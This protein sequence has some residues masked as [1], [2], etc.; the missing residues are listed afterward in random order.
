MAQH[1]YY[2]LGYVLNSPVVALHLLWDT[3]LWASDLA[4]VVDDGVCVCSTE[5][6]RFGGTAHQ[7]R[8]RSESEGVAACSSPMH[9]C[10]ARIPDL[11]AMPNMAE[12]KRVTKKSGIF[13]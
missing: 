9:R 3:I 2:I 4:T 10:T 8:G 12:L 11:F 13:F 7:G 6:F 1:N 5:M